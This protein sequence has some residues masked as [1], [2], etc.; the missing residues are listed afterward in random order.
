[1]HKFS[2]LTGRILLEFASQ[3]LNTLLRQTRG[4]VL[5][6]FGVGPNYR[7]SWTLWHSSGSY[8]RGDVPPMTLAFT[9]SL[10][11]PLVLRVLGILMLAVSLPEQ[12]AQAANQDWQNNGTDFNTGSNWNNNVVPGAGDVARFTSAMGTQPNLSAS[13]TIQELNFSAT[14]A[15]GY[16]LTSSNT[17]IKLTLTNTGTAGASAINAANTSGTNT[18]HAP[19]VLGAGA[20]S[21]Q[22]FTQAAGGSLAVIGVISNTNNVTL[23]KAGTGTLTLAGANTYSGGTTINA[24]TLNINNASALGTGTFTIAGG[25]NAIIDNTTA[26]AITLSTNNAQVWNGNFTFTGTQSLNLGTG[27]VTLGA[28][29]TVTVNGSNLTVGG[30]I[31]GTGFSLTKAGTGTLTLSGANTYTGGTTIGTG[32]S[33]RTL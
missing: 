5:R 8:L 20:G 29:R 28:S 32:A 3:R 6:C 22:T 33:A 1:M 24:G 11:F 26:S 13:R 7:L 16:D 19:I 9:R 21:T 12:S 23:A 25:S 10:S 27:A 14:T 30:V 4:K 15:S 31:S 18:I 17:G 2:F